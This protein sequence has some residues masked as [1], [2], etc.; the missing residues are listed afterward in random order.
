MLFFNKH[1]LHTK[2]VMLLKTLLN[3]YKNN[4]YFY[5]EDVK[6]NNSFYDELFYFE[7]LNFQKTI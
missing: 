4:Y 7:V 2:Y 6:F 1:F 3:P 5:F